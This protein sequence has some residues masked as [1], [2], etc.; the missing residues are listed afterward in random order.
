MPADDRLRAYLNSK[1]NP[2]RRANSENLDVKA[3]KLNTKSRESDITSSVQANNMFRSILNKS[4]GTGTKKGD[5]SN[6]I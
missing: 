1:I 4:Q 2:S 6:I 5:V 3:T